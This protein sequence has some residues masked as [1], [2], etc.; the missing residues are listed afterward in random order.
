MEFIVWGAP[1]SPRGL[2]GASAHGGRD[3]LF[4]QARFSYSRI[5]RYNAGH[6]RRMSHSSHLSASELETG[7]CVIAHSFHISRLFQQIIVVA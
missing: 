5:A 7:H 2:Q 6:I 4:R 3:F 1:V